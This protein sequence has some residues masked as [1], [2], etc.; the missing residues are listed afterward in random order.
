M[1]SEIRLVEEISI[2]MDGREGR[3]LFAA[4]DHILTC[5][6]SLFDIEQEESDA[7]SE[8]YTSLDEAFTAN[9]KERMKK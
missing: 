6:G 4:L 8:L 9:V 2:A 7:L 3:Y 5:G 1:K